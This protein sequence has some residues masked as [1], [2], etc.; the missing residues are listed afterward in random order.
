MH[1]ARNA[2]AATCTPIETISNVQ[3]NK[4]TN[5]TPEHDHHTVPRDSV[6]LPRALDLCREDWTGGRVCGHLCTLHLQPLE[7]PEGRVDGTSSHGGRNARCAL[8]CWSIALVGLKICDKENLVAGGREPV[9][10]GRLE[11]HRAR[12]VQ[13]MRTCAAEAG[14]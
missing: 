9:F 1:M 5:T 8:H 13:R 3:Q 12:C 6:R 14:P 2:E 4:P 7:S 11:S 10:F